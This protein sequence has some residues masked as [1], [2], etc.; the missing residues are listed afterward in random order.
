VRQVKL[1]SNS[2]DSQLAEVDR[3]FQAVERFARE[4][5]RHQGR[6]ND[7]LRSALTELYTFGEMLRTQATEPGR[8]LVQEFVRSKGLPWNAVTQRN[9]YNALVKLAFKQSASSQSQ[10]AAVL[11]YASD[12]RIEPLV[13]GSWLQDGGGIKG[14]YPEA[15]EHY[16]SARKQRNSQERASRLKIAEGLLS[17]REHSRPVALPRGVTADAG[18]ALVL[19]KIDGG[20]NAV[21]IDVVQAERAALE[22]VLLGYAPT[23]AT[24]KAALAAEPLG[25]LYRAIDLVLGCT[26][27]K[28]GG[29]VRHVLLVNALD[30]GRPICRVEALSEA[31]TYTWAGMAL[32]G[33]LHG[34]PPGI[35]FVLRCN[36]AAF[37]RRD[38]PNH[39]EWTVSSDPIPRIH[40]SRRE[41]SL[42]LHPLDPQG[43]YRVGCVP[44]RRHKPVSATYESQQAV[45]RFLN[46]RKLEH[47]RRRVRMKEKQ[48]FP[49]TL[50]I[51]SISGELK[52]GL[53]SMLAASVTFGESS[54]DRDL[55][56]RE[57]ATG[58]LADVL[59]ALA[60]YETPLEGTFIDTD[61]TDA[62]LNLR[63][64]FDDDLLNVVVP[65]RS[66]KAINQSCVDLD[67]G[68]SN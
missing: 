38:F 65:T 48:P 29:N 4:Y 26:D 24:A 63:A 27:D 60:P 20:G 30:R 3:H 6:S 62:A 54:P 9:P 43:S 44:V 53:P 11:S 47:D 35:P 28:T 40:N 68:M 55:G 33:H 31:Y 17:S 1:V 23:K 41:Y 5:E 32:S 10:Y 19:A 67:L 50:T 42:Q 61:V 36:D 14:R 34:L 59:R 46:D 7:L 21:I 45:L 12:C 39:D 52:L 64:W 56:E 13:F 66:G 37:F 25:H 22:P 49:P 58:E 15:A 16:G 57:L 18:F 2:A 51:Q 8:S